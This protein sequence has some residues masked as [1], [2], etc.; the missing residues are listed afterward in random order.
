MESPA[1][2]LQELRTFFGWFSH[3]CTPITAL[4]VPKGSHQRPQH[5]T[6]AQGSAGKA[7]T[8]PARVSPSLL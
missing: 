1:Q 3:A 6:Q 5:R 4:A 2:H 8:A 7:T